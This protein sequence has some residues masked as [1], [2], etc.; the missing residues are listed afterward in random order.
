MRNSIRKIFKIALLLVLTSCSLMYYKEGHIIEKT[1]YSF[2]GPP[3]NGWLMSSKGEGYTEFYKPADNS[4]LLIM[5]AEADFDEKNHRYQSEEEVVSHLYNLMASRTLHCLS[6][7]TKTGVTERDN[8]KIYFRH[9][10]STGCNKGA[11]ALGGVMH[12][13]FPPNFSIQH[14]FFV[15]HLVLPKDKEV[16]YEDFDFSIITQ[17]IESFRIKHPH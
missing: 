7:N 2:I 5:Y 6:N 8:E 4:V 15:F 3:G 12:I 1:N 11:P 14:K 13:L 17:V 10:V 9:T 16:A